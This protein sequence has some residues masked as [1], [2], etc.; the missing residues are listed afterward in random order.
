M[1]EDYLHTPFPVV[2]GLLKKRKYIEESN[3]LEKYDFSYV[4]LNP[5]RADIYYQ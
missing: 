2:Y 3:I 1:D 4:F 5:E